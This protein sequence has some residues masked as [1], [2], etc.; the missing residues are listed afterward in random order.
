MENKEEPS[1]AASASS[2][3]N[4]TVRCHSPALSHDNSNFILTGSSLSY[5][6]QGQANAEKRTNQP[7]G[8]GGGNRNNPKPQAPSGTKA[9]LRS[10]SVP[11][12]SP[13]PDPE[14]GPL[15]KSAAKPTPLIIPKNQ[16][17]TSS[18]AVKTPSNPSESS[19]S[20]DTDAT[21]ANIVAQAQMRMMQSFVKQ[22]INVAITA[23]NR[24]NKEQLKEIKKELLDVLKS[25]QVDIEQ[26]LAFGLFNEVK[27]AKDAVANNITEKQ[28]E[29]LQKS[30]KP[31]D[32]FRQE[33]ENFQAFR[34]TD[35][36]PDSIRI[37]PPSTGDNQLLS[38]TAVVSAMPVSNVTATSTAAAVQPVPTVGSSPTVTTIIK[39]E[40]TDTSSSTAVASVF[41]DDS[42]DA[43]HASPVSIGLTSQVVTQQN[44]MIKKKVKH[45]LLASDLTALPS[46]LPSAFKRPVSPPPDMI[47]DSSSD[48]IPQPTR[49]KSH[50][51]SASFVAEESILVR[52]RLTER[53]RNQGTS[54]DS[55]FMIE[56]EQRL[57]PLQ[58]K[59]MYMISCAQAMGDKAVEDLAWREYFHEENN[60]YNR[61]IVEVAHASLGG[62]SSSSG[63]GGGKGTPAQSTAASSTSTPA[64]S[65]AASS[66]SGTAPAKSTKYNS[67]TS[68]S[69]PMGAGDPSDDDDGDSDSGSADRKSNAGSET[70]SSSKRHPS[71]RASSSK[72]HHP[73]RHASSSNRKRR[74]LKKQ[75]TPSFTSKSTSKSAKSASFSP[76]MSIHDFFSMFMGSPGPP[77]PSPSG[78][79]SDS[80]D[81]P[82]SDGE[83]KV[84]HNGRI[85]NDLG[86]RAD[87]KTRWEEQRNSDALKDFLNHEL[88]Y[89]WFTPSA[90]ND[91]KLTRWLRTATAVQ[92]KS[93]GL[94][95]DMTKAAKP[96]ATEKIANDLTARRIASGHP[97]EFGFNPVTL[98]SLQKY[99]GQ[100]RLCSLEAIT[101]AIA[102]RV[103]SPDAS[104]FFERLSHLRFVAT[105]ALTSDDDTLH[106]NIP[107]VLLELATFVDDDVLHFTK[108]FASEFNYGFNVV[109]QYGTQQTSF[110]SVLLNLIPSDIRETLEHK[111]WLSSTILADPL[112]CQGRDYAK[113]LRHFSS[114]LRHLADQA[115]AA[116]RTISW[117]KRTKNSNWNKFKKDTSSLRILDLA[118]DFTE[119]AAVSSLDQDAESLPENIDDELLIGEDG[120]DYAVVPDDDDENAFERISGLNMMF[121][122]QYQRYPFNPA[123]A[124]QPFYKS[125]SGLQRPIF[126]DKRNGRA[127]DKYP[128]RSSQ[129]SQYSSSLPRSN[130]SKP[131]RFT[132]VCPDAM[133]GAVCPFSCKRG[134]HD[135]R[136][137]Q[138]AKL[139]YQ[140]PSSMANQS[141]TAP[142][143][144]SVQMEGG[145]DTR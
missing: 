94:P 110:S 54:L 81:D 30:T 120:I 50:H 33:F 138:R 64:Q 143:P 73:K 129:S 136:D 65:A 41:L 109:S 123:K 105:A 52:Q 34:R 44:P 10:S 133:R 36:A 141:P 23:I 89:A 51:S 28:A 40:Q 17:S 68:S 121:S 31:L 116:Q 87:P 29:E 117:I 132:V 72:R 37:V 125:G 75:K 71:Q 80:D 56:I 27:K 15:A 25:T 95:P 45:V 38:S 62:K 114:V 9:K 60:E 42:F 90:A 144:T 97:P 112:A 49:P 32:R 57:K 101:K 58:D 91:H 11:K 59:R 134:S 19:A 21:D 13:S 35:L 3:S 69:M 93:N 48:D 102:R 124:K 16:S 14:Y 74:G 46:T 127:V 83:E 131:F 20:E 84:D 85:L 115:M 1:A 118:E 70:S 119:H 88:D 66:T 39:S 2:E 103:S 22:T 8:R 130:G 7:G 4:A 126:Y 137:I 77:P 104:M 128:S 100:Y 24:E 6:A 108:L 67:G 55:A 82:P 106:S 92:I 98:R 26:K 12:A 135:H 47:T 43:I 76:S 139:R 107:S 63:N 140:S 113:F 18:K 86:Q 99:K 78:S 96:N 61:L 53:A 142:P 122:T 145:R 79:D 5:Q 111:L